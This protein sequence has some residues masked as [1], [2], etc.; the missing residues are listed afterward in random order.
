[1]ATSKGDPLEAAA[2]AWLTSVS[3]RPASFDAMSGKWPRMAAAL[4]DGAV[5]RR[6]ARQRGVR[7]AAVKMDG[8]DPPQT[9]SMT[10]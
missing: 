7:P 3:P 2:P 8:V 4:K 10:P 1:M 9:P 6:T 5:A